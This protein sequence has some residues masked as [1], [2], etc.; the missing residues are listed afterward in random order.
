MNTEIQELKKIFKEIK[1]KQFSSLRKGT[2]GIGYT[3]EKLI[4]KEEDNLFLPDFKG[5]EI[6]TKLGYTKSPLTL[7]CLTPKKDNTQCIKYLLKTYGY[8]NKNLKYKSFRIDVYANK[9]NILANKYIFKLKVDNIEK[10]LKLLILDINFNIIDDTIYWNF[11]D[12]E[13]RLYTKL[14]YLAYITGYPYQNDNKK[15]YKYTNLKIFKLKGFNKFLE[16][17]EKNIIQVTFN[18]GYFRTGKRTG[19][20]HDRG[21]TFRLSNDSILELFTLIDK[22]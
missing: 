10:K 19:E 14:N 16:L 8:P 5:I 21:T 6:K 1:N 20:I 4:N 15:H 3:L 17:I 11:K 9:N 12:I 13:T 18:I 22:A 7:F 2:T